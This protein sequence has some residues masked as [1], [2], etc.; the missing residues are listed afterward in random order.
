MMCFSPLSQFLL[1]LSC[2]ME[3]MKEALQQNRRPPSPPRFTAERF[4]AANPLLSGVLDPALGLKLVVEESL[5]EIYAP[6]WDADLR[7]VC[8]SSRMPNAGSTRAA[9][10]LSSAAY[11]AV[12]AQDNDR[13]TVAKAAATELAAMGVE[14][15]KAERIIASWSAQHLMDGRDPGEHT[16]MAA[17]VGRMLSPWDDPANW[18]LL[19]EPLQVLMRPAHAFLAPPPKGAS[20]AAELRPTAVHLRAVELLRVRL[21]RSALDGGLS[22]TLVASLSGLAK[23]MRKRFS[24]FCFQPSA[25]DTAVPE[26]PPMSISVYFSSLREVE[27]CC[28]LLLQLE[29]ESV[30]WH[31]KVSE[32]VAALARTPAET[33]NDSE[34]EKIALVKR[35]VPPELQ[36]LLPLA[37]PWLLFVEAVVSDVERQL[38]GS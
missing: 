6:R 1:Q 19:L 35:A 7:A 8:V 34:V 17:V 33:I 11:Y 32:G 31:S 38:S 2:R 29:K 16:P 21:L 24:G 4:L 14:I 18:V 3:F 28:S 5:E 10:E 20:R 22:S 27:Q 12:L 23:R 37:I 25:A 30:V 15:E 9:L 13:G 36:R 26:D